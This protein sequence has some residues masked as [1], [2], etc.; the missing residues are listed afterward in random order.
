LIYHRSSTEEANCRFIGEISN[1]LKK[2][3][4]GGFFFDLEKAAD[5]D[6]CGILLSK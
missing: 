4:V 2:V 6:N 5:C 3:I 1:V